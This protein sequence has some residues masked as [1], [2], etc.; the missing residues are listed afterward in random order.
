MA[1]VPMAKQHYVAYLQAIAGVSR[2]I[3]NGSWQ[4]GFETALAGLATR[5]ELSDSINAYERSTAELL[6]WRAKVTTAVLQRETK[7]YPDLYTT[8][9][10]TLAYEPPSLGFY[11][12][13][14][15][16]QRPTIPCLYDAIPKSFPWALSVMQNRTVNVPE[17]FYR[18]G[19]TK[20]LMSRYRQGYYAKSVSAPEPVDAIGRLKNDL[21]VDTDHPPLTLKAA[22]AISSAERGEYRNV[23]GVVMNM[24]LEGSI[25]RF[26]VIPPE[27]A[28]VIEFT[29]IQLRAD[30]GDELSGLVIRYDLQP[31]W[32]AHDYFF[33]NIPTTR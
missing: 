16:S 13:I 10:N 11:R 14:A 20:V 27:E 33:Y 18:L 12:T 1:P 7:N 32:L 23:G 30:V 19:E 24:G 21:L 31:Q 9:Q 28:S 3:D 6:K 25:S 17:S 5:A 4:G 2:R 29:Q 8:S 15:G 26:A 22:S